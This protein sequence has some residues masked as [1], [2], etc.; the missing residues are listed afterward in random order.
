MLTQHLDTRVKIVYGRAPTKVVSSLLF[1]SFV[2]LMVLYAS[3][4]PPYT[5]MEVLLVLE[6]IIVVYT[7]DACMSYPKRSAA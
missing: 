4:K 5:P 1:D 7:V 6:P 3:L 2:P